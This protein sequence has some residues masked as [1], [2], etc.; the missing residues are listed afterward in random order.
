MTAH[1]RAPLCMLP[2]CNLN[3]KSVHAVHADIM[4]CAALKGKVSQS[5]MSDMRVMVQTKYSTARY[6]STAVL[7]RLKM[8]VYL[9]KQS[10][11]L[12]PERWS[13]VRGEADRG[14]SLY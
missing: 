5:C 4:S 8:R 1:V 3:S 14:I 12:S 2:S 9:G 7:V 6:L 13:Q 11:V 10:S